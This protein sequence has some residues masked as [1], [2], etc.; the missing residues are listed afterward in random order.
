MKGA[1][2]KIRGLVIFWFRCTFLKVEVLIFLI[3]I[4]TFLGRGVA[5]NIW[6]LF[7]VTSPLFQDYGFESLFLILVG[8]FMVEVNFLTIMVSFLTITLS[9]FL[10]SHTFF[11][12]L[13]IIDHAFTFEPF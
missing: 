11:D 9:I 1:V 13:H 8:V 3:T 4:T 2:V 5:F 6:R 7:K 12:A 10:N